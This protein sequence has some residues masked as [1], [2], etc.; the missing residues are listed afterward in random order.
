MSVRV[1][2]IS[3]AHVY[4]CACVCIYVYMCVCMFMCVYMYCLAG[5]SPSPPS[6]ITAVSLTLGSVGNLTCLA[7]VDTKYQIN[8]CYTSASN[9]TN[10]SA[11]PSQ[12]EGPC[13][14][15]PG[16]PRWSVSSAVSTTVQ[17][18]KQRSVSVIMDSVGEDDAG[19][20]SYYWVAVTPKLYQSYLVTVDRAGTG[21]WLKMV[22]G[23]S[24]AT[25]L[26]I[27]VGIVVSLCMRRR[28]K[29]RCA[30]FRVIVFDK[31]VCFSQV[32]LVSESGEGQ[33]QS[34][35]TFE[36]KV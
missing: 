1:R 7:N 32:Q 26:L 35:E 25:L 4:V 20:V 27:V 9:R 16:K 34:G 14:A 23:V 28:G 21:L 22:M 12:S 17:G 11:C 24:A 29:G 3:H 31:L 13:P 18:C 2:M 8:V 6:G 36:Q 33:I 30:L 19:T 10:C 15:M 5:S